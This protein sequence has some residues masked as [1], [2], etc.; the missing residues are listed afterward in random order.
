GSTDGA[1]DG[2][3]GTDGT[4]TGDTG[5]G[6]TGDGTTGDGTTGDGQQDVESVT[7]TLDAD[8]SI[9]LIGVTAEDVSQ[10]WFIA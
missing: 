7:I 5:D 10:D 2:A 4:Q 9:T 1:G 3:G 6:T 8:N